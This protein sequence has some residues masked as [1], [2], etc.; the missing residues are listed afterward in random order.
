VK[1][2]RERIEEAE[3]MGVRKMKAQLSAMD[4]R[5]RSLEEQ[6]DVATK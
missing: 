5:V 2:L 3:S 1:D 6:L 4:S